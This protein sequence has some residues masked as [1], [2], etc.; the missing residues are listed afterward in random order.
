MLDDADWWQNYKD[1]LRRL[2]EDPEIESGNV[3][4]LASMQ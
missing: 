2:N 3:I 4:D 1:K